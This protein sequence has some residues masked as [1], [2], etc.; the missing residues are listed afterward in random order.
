LQEIEDHIDDTD[1]RHPIGKHWDPFSVFEL[2]RWRYKDQGHSSSL[3][4]KK[5][6]AIEPSMHMQ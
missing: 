1:Q 4:K 5:S 6:D 2:F 3:K